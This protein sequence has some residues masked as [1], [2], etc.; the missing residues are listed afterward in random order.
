MNAR[1]PIDLI[2]CLEQRT[3]DVPGRRIAT[4]AVS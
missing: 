4:E 2:A 3:R 1:C